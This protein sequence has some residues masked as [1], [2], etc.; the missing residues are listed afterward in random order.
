MSLLS[1][2]GSFAD[3]LAVLR[4]GPF[5]HRPP[6]QH[7]RG[8][9]AVSEGDYTV[10]IVVAIEYDGGSSAEHA[11]RYCEWIDSWGSSSSRYRDAESED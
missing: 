10:L 6:G 4:D 5:L 11:S 1:E 8:R 2:T 3:L 9:T 7:I